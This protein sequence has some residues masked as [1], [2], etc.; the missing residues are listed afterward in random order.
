MTRS[1]QAVSREM[2]RLAT[3]GLL[4]REGGD[5]RVPDLARL[6]KLVREAKGE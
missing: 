3:M 5:L 2:S 6:E 4:R 1:R